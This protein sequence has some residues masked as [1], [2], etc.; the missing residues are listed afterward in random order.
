MMETV[1]IRKNKN[2][3]FL[4]QEA[5]KNLRTN[6]EFSGVD[7]RTICVTS[8]LPDDGKSTVSLNLAKAFAQ[9]GKLTLLIDADLRK[10]VAVQN[11]VKPAVPCGLAHLLVGKAA[12]EE[13]LCQTD[14]ENFYVMFAGSFPPNPSELLDTE[15][16]RE[17]INEAK[18][19][20]DCIIIDT[21]PIG[22]VIDAAIVAKACDGVV[23]VV[24]S[25]RVSYRFAQRVKN[26]LEVSGAKILGCVLND[27]D[28]TGKSKYSGYKRYYRGYYKRYY[29]EYSSSNNN[30]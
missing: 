27:V 8:A 10:S 28:I 7:V 13:A 23:F 25:G 1:V 17:L 29:K 9:N 30:Q 4:S 26:Q 12:F 3:S 24:R 5:F 21:P 11:F 2:E 14:L 22:S 16:F 20:F 6:I 19:Y 18:E 15:R